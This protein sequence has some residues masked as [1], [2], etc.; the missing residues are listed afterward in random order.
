M[1]VRA[2]GVLLWAC[3]G[4]AQGDSGSGCGAFTP[5]AI[6][7][8]GTVALPPWAARVPS[9]TAWVR[10]SAPLA[11]S[12]SSPSP[13]VEAELRMSLGPSLELR[14]RC[15]LPVPAHPAFS[16]RPSAAAVGP[17]RAILSVRLRS[18]F[19]SPVRVLSASVAHLPP[20]VA[21]AAPCHPQPLSLPPGAEAGL[22]FDV[23]FA[24][25]SA[26]EKLNGGGGGE[27][28]SGGSSGGAT[29]GWAI[30]RPAGSLRAA[31]LTP[32]QQGVS[33]RARAAGA[34][35]SAGDEAAR[36]GTAGGLAE[37]AVM[38]SLVVTYEVVRGG[39][40][41]LDAFAAAQSSCAALGAPPPPPPSPSAAAPE[42]VV[43]ATFPLSPQALRA[44]QPPALAA[45]MR[46]LGPARAGE[47]VRFVWDVAP[48]PAALPG[49]APL[50][51]RWLADGPRTS[52]LCLSPCA[53]EVDF[54]SGQPSS[55][56]SL[57]SPRAPSFVPR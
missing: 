33:P 8:D 39:G 23:S 42:A 32:G 3:G 37:G 13:S 9:L 49:C 2:A 12:F 34:A 52:W 56:G 10:A 31:H 43:V 28:G 48:L 57:A 24:E 50:H 44:L 19:D 54:A 20:N 25:A 14:P 11:S 35:A 1:I 22:L 6:A 41:A 4:G 53:G 45:R 55:E 51:L 21:R 16:A 26:A 36:A 17:G 29:D 40:N 27:S 47:A 30:R 46:P 15:A 7:D 38:P 5:A 18:L